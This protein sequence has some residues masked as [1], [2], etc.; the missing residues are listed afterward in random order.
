MN[1]PIAFI[2]I[3]RIQ[4]VIA[5]IKQLLN[6]IGEIIDEGIAMPDLVENDEGEFVG[7]RWRYITFRS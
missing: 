3:A 5:N 4:I 1:H 7:T 6:V 2:L